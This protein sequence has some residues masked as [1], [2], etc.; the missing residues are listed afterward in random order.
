[1]N[2]CI[3]SYFSMISVHRW[4]LQ[5]FKFISL[6][7]GVLQF[8]EILEV[9]EDPANQLNQ[10]VPKNKMHVFS[11]NNK[12][13]ILGEFETVSYFVKLLSK[14][15]RLPFS[16]KHFG[17][18]LDEFPLWSYLVNPVFVSLVFRLVTGSPGF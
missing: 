15:T 13:T 17:V 8:L 4:C 10:V 16:A 1:M 12:H 3:I 7:L 18:Q 6:Y 5:Y 14:H 9:P 11:V 2:I